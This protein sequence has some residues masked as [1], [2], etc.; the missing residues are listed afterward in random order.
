MDSLKALTAGGIIPDPRGDGTEDG[1]YLLLSGHG[2]WIRLQDRP[3]VV[4][5]IAGGLQDHGIVELCDVSDVERVLA[6]MDTA[7]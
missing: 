2:A 3:G 5:H 4:L 1:D 6:Y 7:L